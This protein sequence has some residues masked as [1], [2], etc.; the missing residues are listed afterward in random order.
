M[1]NYRYEVF[2]DFEESIFIHA[3][4]VYEAFIR[5]SAKKIDFDLRGNYRARLIV[6]E[7]LDAEWEVSNMIFNKVK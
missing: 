4:G 2:F 5:A 3:A 7:E 1:K 6:C